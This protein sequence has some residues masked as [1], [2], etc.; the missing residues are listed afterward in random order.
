MHYSLVLTFIMIYFLAINNTNVVYECLEAD[1][2][3]TFLTSRRILT[4]VS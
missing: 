1:G 3:N 2:V 4:S